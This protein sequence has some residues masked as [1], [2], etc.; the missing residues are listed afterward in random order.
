MELSK[1]QAIAKPPESSELGG[2]C[3]KPPGGR[4][5]SQELRSRTVR[6]GND[7]EAREFGMILSSPITATKGRI[8]RTISK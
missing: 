3:G 1:P 4:R 7:I 2:V 5:K 8:G 6:G